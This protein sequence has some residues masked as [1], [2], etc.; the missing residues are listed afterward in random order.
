MNEQQP[1]NS[2]TNIHSFKNYAI[3]GA[4]G[5]LMGVGIGTVLTFL[6]LNIL[7]PLEFIIPSSFGDPL[8]FLMRFSSNFIIF[9]VFGIYMGHIAENE[10]EFARLGAAAGIF[11]GMAAAV[12][13]GILTD[14]ET[15]RFAA[16]IIVLGIAGLVFGVPRI[17][18]MVLIA[19]SGLLGG[20][21][22]TAIYFLAQYLTYFLKD[23]GMQHN[24]GGVFF[25]PL[26]LM[27]LLLTLLAVG[28]P[29][30]LIGVGI[31]IAG[32]R[33]Y[34]KRETPQYLKVMRYLGQGLVIMVLL[35]MSVMFIS[36][37]DYASASTSI[38]MSS[39]T[40]ETTL[41]VPVLLDDGEVMEMYEHPTVNGD[42]ATAIIDTQYGKALRITGSGDIEIHMQQSLGIQRG[43]QPDEAFGGFTLSMGN[44]TVGENDRITDVR[45]YTDGEVDDLGIS[46]S[47]DTGWGQIQEI[48]TEKNIDPD[49]GWQV[50]RL[51][52]SVLCYD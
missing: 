29:G 21:V 37:A 33:V 32:G 23:M 34:S 48:A 20:T 49:E 31:Y 13:G 45:I 18:N 5:L 1:L 26:I 12:L 3:H 30:A 25:I 10:K 50:V 52:V 44:Y 47:M 7:W 14:Y 17:R 8:T 4:F 16:Y 42:A 39:G 43:K 27:L 41:Y 35:F 19:V 2:D 24:L 40:G 28:I 15:T 11:C 9:T 46:F 22:G 6:L 38:R 51:V 36:M